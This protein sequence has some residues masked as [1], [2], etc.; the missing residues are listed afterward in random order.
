MRT[1]GVGPPEERVPQPETT[2]FPE[3]VCPLRGMSAAETALQTK[4]EEICTLNH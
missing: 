1:S 4:G 3:K 2:A